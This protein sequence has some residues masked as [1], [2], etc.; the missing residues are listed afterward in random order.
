MQYESKYLK[1]KLKYLKLCLSLQ[2]G[3][4]KEQIKWPQDFRK[5]KNR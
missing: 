5:N 3:G 2:K 1:Y 4:F